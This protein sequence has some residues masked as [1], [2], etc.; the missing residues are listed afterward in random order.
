MTALGIPELGRFFVLAAVVFAAMGAI[1]GLAAGAKRSIGGWHWARSA[2]FGFAGSMIAANVLMVVALVTHEAADELTANPGT[3]VAVR[4]K[5]TA[6]HA[7][8][9]GSAPVSDGPL[10]DGAGPAEGDGSEVGAT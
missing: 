4:V 2:A 6:L 8:P 7:F 1:T 10:A 3:R 5:A 9:T